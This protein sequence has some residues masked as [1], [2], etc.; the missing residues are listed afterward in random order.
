MCFFVQTLFRE[1][2]EDVWNLQK[3]WLLLN[4]TANN[5]SSTFTADL[6]DRTAFLCVTDRTNQRLKTKIDNRMPFTFAINVIILLMQS[7]IE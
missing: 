1:I 6:H 2:V 5:W 3:N 7:Y 4:T